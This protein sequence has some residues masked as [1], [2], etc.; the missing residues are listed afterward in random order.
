[1]ET[2]ENRPAIT[3]HA[4][5]GS[6]A[7]LVVA[8]ALAI[9]A[10]YFSSH[11][12]RKLEM[13]LNGARAQHAEAKA[14]LARAHEDEREIQQKIERFREIV[15][16]GRTEPEQRLDWVETLRAI[17]ESRR[18]LGLEYEIAPQRLLDEK[19]PASGGHAFLASPMRVELPLLHENDLLGLLS[20]LTVRTQALVSVRSCR[21]ER[22]PLGSASKASLQARCDIDWITLQ[23]KM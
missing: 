22:V 5:G 9:A 2:L 1:M 8:C 19:Q 23:E 11:E 3:L 4:L 14:R 16:R 20:E 21:I 17:K 7:L 13:S 18:L 10:G 12:H 15:A 6:I